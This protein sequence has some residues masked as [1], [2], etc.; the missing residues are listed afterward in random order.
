MQ[1]SKLLTG[2]A[3]LNWLPTSGSWY[4]ISNKADPVRAEIFLYDEIGYFGVTAA[5]FVQ[6]LVDITAP[7]ILVHLSSRGGDVFDGVAIFNALR[8][9]EARIT[10]QV[11]SLAASVA[12]VIAQAGDTRI[13]VTGSQMMI[14][15]AWGL[16]VGNA[17]D[18][19]DFA[20]TLDK[21]TDNIAAIYAERAGDG[22]KKSHYRSLMRDETW[23]NATEAV[24]EG[25]ADSVTKPDTGST[26]PASTEGEDDGEAVDVTDFIT[27]ATEI[28]AA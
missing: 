16:A 26:V 19:R 3:V 27:S 14:H 23:M 15:D 1:S 28:G 11:D 4:S 13:M 25:L 10:V 7:E 6:E 8:T 17:E 9:H 5:D 18:M 22:R 12:S 2:P 21:Q 24:A 20:D